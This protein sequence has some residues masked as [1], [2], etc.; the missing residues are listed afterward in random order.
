M[1]NVELTITD[2]PLHS[3]ILPIPTPPVCSMTNYS[4]IEIM[5]FTKSFFELTISQICMY[6]S[7]YPINI[8]EIDFSFDFDLGLRLGKFSQNQC[9]PLSTNWVKWV[10]L[11]LIYNNQY[12]LNSYL[13]QIFIFRVND[14][15][16]THGFS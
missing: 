3:Q 9:L 5:L 12:F 8:F 10:I 14:D 7:M 6:E 11:S 13:F 4:N 1:E 2:A 15:V 16:S